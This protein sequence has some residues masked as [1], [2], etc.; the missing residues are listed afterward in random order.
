MDVLEAVVAS[1]DGETDPRC[2]MLMFNAVRELIT[3]Y[4]RLGGAPS[5]KLQQVRD[6]LNPERR[7]HRNCSR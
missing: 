5:Q 1:S 7:H 4:S 6:V 2:L 3:L